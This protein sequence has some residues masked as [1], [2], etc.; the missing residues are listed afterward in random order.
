[1][2]L[3]E[4]PGK[5]ALPQESRKT[6]CFALEEGFVEETVRHHRYPQFG[7]LELA[8]QQRGL[9]PVYLT[10]REKEKPCTP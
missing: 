3:G 10:H 9:F 8:A 6:C 2:P 1:M 5:A 4:Q 7:W